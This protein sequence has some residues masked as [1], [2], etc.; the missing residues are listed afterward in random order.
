M[1]L[2]V[3]KKREHTVGIPTESIKKLDWHPGDHL[4]W[5]VVDGKLMLVNMD[6]D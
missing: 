1:K 5:K 6:R 4:A 3:N 2:R